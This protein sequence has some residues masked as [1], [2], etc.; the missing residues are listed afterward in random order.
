MKKPA[1]REKRFSSEIF[2]ETNWTMSSK[3]IGQYIFRRISIDQSSGKLQKLRP[4]HQ[5]SQLLITSREI[6]AYVDDYLRMMDNKTKDNFRTNKRA[7]KEIN[8][9]DNVLERDNYLV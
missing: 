4:R 8:R 3:N 6:N 7:V 9:T 5:M 1:L 2:E